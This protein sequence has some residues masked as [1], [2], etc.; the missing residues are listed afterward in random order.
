MYL[1][2]S[3]GLLDS[4]VTVLV[5]DAYCFSNE[6][7][8]TP[9]R[10]SRNEGFFPSGGNGDCDSKLPCGCGGKKWLSSDSVS[11]SSLS[12]T[13]HAPE[14]LIQSLH[15]KC[16][17]GAVHC[18]GSNADKNPLDSNISPKNIQCNKH[19]F[20]WIGVLFKLISLLLP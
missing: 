9:Q 20:T 10:K 13:P 1:A 8:F 4:I 7:K 17:S 15:D 11:P 12:N 19:C 3:Y 2:I 16:G 14:D 5:C 18:A 6:V